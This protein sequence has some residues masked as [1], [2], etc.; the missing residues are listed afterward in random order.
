MT[1]LKFWAPLA[2]VAAL[3]GC[4]GGS[5]SLPA[6]ALPTMPSQGDIV[7]RNGMAK[8]FFGAATGPAALPPAPIGSYA[9]GCLAGGTQLAETGATWQAMRLSRNRN[10][11]HPQTV[12][13]I[14]DLSRSIARLP[15]TEGIYVGDLSQPKGGPML[16]GHRS[17]QIGMDADIWLMPARIGLDR[18]ERERI[19]AVSYRRDRG[20]FVNEKWSRVQHELVKAAANDPRL[21][22][23]FIFPGAKVRMCA[24]ETGNRDWLRKVRPWYGH[25][26]HF[27]ARLSCPE[28]ARDCVDQAAPPPGDGCAEAQDWVDNILNPPPPDPNAPPAKPRSELQMAD[29]PAQCQSVLAR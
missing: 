10:W 28:G 15:E 22:R 26:Y 5:R 14:E 13:F 16:T 21:A 2:L 4:S 24:D 29:L 8:T 1:F 27:H 19:S 18:A 23:I 6:S 9:K 11:A 25:H 3:A 20:A 17:H 7:T 12:D